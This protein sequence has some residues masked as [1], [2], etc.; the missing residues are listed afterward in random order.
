MET[1]NEKLD[2]T[3]GTGMG[4]FKKWPSPVEH[5]YRLGENKRLR[6]SGSYFLFSQELSTVC[7]SSGKMKI[8]FQ[9]KH[10]KTENENAS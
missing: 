6:E 9:T 5:T 10:K 2:G 1:V 3:Y 4:R 7:F 8:V